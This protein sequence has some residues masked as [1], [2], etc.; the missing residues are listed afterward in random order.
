MILYPY[1]RAF[2]VAFQGDG[3]GSIVKST[4]KFHTALLLSTIVFGLVGESAGLM[5]L[6]IGRGDS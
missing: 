5:F 2:F 3:V 1:R 6:L 4:D